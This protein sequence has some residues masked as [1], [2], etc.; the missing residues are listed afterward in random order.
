MKI[1][2]SPRAR[3]LVVEV[4]SELPPVSLPEIGLKKILVPVDFSESSRKAF[5]YA[6]SFARQFAAEILLLH[7]VEFIPTPELVVAESGYLNARLRE[8]ATRELANWRK[9]MEPF[10]LK[11]SVEDGIPHREIVRIADEINADLIILGTEGRTG[12]SHL[13][14]GSTA[15]RV[16]RHAHCPVMVVR[17][18]EHDFVQE[19]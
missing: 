1:K 9:E 6:V 16:V 10:Q 4:E 15:E 12:L 11:T 19:K 17:Q 14:I 3:K 7:I 18:R 2:A 5:A 8:N 13:L